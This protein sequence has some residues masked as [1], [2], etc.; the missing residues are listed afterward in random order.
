M[1]RGDTDPDLEIGRRKRYSIY[2]TVFILGTRGDGKA[3]HS[4]QVSSPDGSPCIREECN[5]ELASSWKPNQNGA[6]YAC[7]SCYTTFGTGKKVK[8]AADPKQTA[9]TQF[10]KKQ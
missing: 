4:P 8:A 1:A 5:K 2:F 9:I 3:T 7:I 10:F 6:G